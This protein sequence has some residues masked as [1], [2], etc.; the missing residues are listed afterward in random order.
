MRDLARRCRDS[1]RHQGVAGSTPPAVL[2]PHDVRSLVREP[3]SHALGQRGLS[4]RSAAA[5]TRPS[6]L[7][8]ARLVA[9]PLH[10][11]HAWPAHPFSG[12]NSSRSARPEQKLF[13]SLVRCLKGTPRKIFQIF[14]F[15][16]NRKT[17]YMHVRAS[18][19]QSF[20]R[21]QD[22][23]GPLVQKLGPGPSGGSSGRN[24]FTCF[25]RGQ[26]RRLSSTVVT[27]S[28]RQT[29]ARH[30]FHPGGYFSR[31]PSLS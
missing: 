13:L 2:I 18:P 20:S 19:G 1:M 9:A 30:G 21:K 31:A 14:C 11:D 29:T 22:E 12:P 24:C 25:D 4:A 3:A 5:D 16:E 17:L 7:T 28:W 8:V 15:I 10:H 27:K 6:C 23:N 26:P